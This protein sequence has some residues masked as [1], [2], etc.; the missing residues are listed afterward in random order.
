MGCDLAYLGT[1]FIA[2]EE[3]LAP[4]PYRDMLCRASAADI[5]YT[6]FFSGVP[7][8]YLAPSIAAA[9]LDPVELGSMPSVPAKHIAK[10]DE[11]RPW[12]DIW[13]AGQGAGAVQEV[14]P[15]AALVEQLARE[16]GQARAGL[17][18][19]PA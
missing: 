13:G 16:Y 10:R 11:P 19:K 1:R 7:G 3:S 4:A 6:P 14:L 12:K 18:L 8:N 17:N 9:G 5:V 2:T 15:A